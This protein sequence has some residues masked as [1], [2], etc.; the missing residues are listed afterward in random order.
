MPHIV[1]NLFMYQCDK[2]YRNR[3]IFK[4]VQKQKWCSFLDTVYV[5]CVPIKA[6]N[7]RVHGYLA[8]S[9]EGFRLLPTSCH[10]RIKFVFLFADLYNCMLAS[11]TRSVTMHLRKSIAPFRWSSY[12]AG[13]PEGPDMR[14]LP[15]PVRRPSVRRLS[16]GHISKTKQDRPVVWN[17]IRKLLSLILLPH[18]NPSPDAPLGRFWFQI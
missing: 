17:T 10:W 5:T 4:L 9:F 18:S 14:W 12:R 16:H 8:A 7:S 2:S 15:T 11:I 3:L 13:P 1:G 6:K